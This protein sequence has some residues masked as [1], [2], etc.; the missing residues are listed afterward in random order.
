MTKKT[1]EEI[2]SLLQRAVGHHRNSEWEEAERGYHRVLQNEPAHPDAL[3]LLGLVNQQKGQTVRAEDLVRK[4]ISLDGRAP[5]FYLSLGNIL[6]A[7]GR[8]GEAMESFRQALRLEP[9]LPEA[10]YN[11]AN[12]LLRADRIEESVFHYQ[13]ALRIKPDFPEGY[14]NLGKAFEKLDRLA[15]AEAS[16]RQAVE[17]NPHYFDAWFN[18]AICLSDQC[19]LKEAERCYRRVLAMRPDD[20]DSHWNLSL[21]WLLAG[22]LKEGWPKYEWRLR[23]P[24][25]QFLQPRKKR[26]QGEGAPAKTLLVRAEQG[27]GDVIQF[28]RFLP[29]LKPKVGRLLFECQPSLTPLFRNFSG[30]DQMFSRKADLSPPDVSYDM[31]APLLS[32][33]GI[34]GVTLDSIPAQVPYISPEKNRVED[35]KRRIPPGTKPMKIGIAWAGHV[36]HRG[37]S[38]R[39]TSLFTW[40]PLAGIRGVTFFSLQLGE[41]A[42]EAH[43][44]PSGMDLF[45]L[46]DFIGDFADTAAFISLLDLVISV[47]TGV[48]HLAGAMGR[49]VWTLLP[50][51]PD[52][53]WLLGRKN[54]PWYPTM[55]LFRQ[56]V[57]GD[58]KGVFEEVASTLRE[59]SESGIPLFLSGGTAESGGN[60]EVD[61]DDGVQ[62]F[63]GGKGHDL[64]DSFIDKSTQRQ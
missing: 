54:S 3:H 43:N 34:L 50:F 51:T 58:W 37:N 53:R 41:A 26:W 8:G 32:L 35:W 62:L 59:I 11:L 45:D 38:K 24:K 46:T 19:K 42:V 7:Q 61:I 21:V 48:A 29:L 4:A 57:P 2:E 9:R 20:V 52:W 16:Y 44:S 60:I 5:I 56:R 36:G 30:I 39:S 63:G 12:E 31:E 47:D 6:S 49:P 17:R 13:E 15:E 18:L 28:V 10:H 1:K 55:R 64:K 33:A 27:L 22:N 40:A 14:Y 23:Q 25:Y